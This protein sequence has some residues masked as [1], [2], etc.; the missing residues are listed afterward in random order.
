MTALQRALDSLGFMRDFATVKERE[1]RHT[2]A[3]IVT[4]WANAIAP[5]L[6]GGG[7]A[8]AWECREKSRHGWHAWDPCSQDHFDAFQNDT[9]TGGVSCR[10][11]MEVR[12]LYAHQAPKLPDDVREAMDALIFGD[13]IT[14]ADRGVLV[15]YLQ[16]IDN[17]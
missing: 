2:L 16:E 6:E 4:R 10:E 5:A 13:P 17:G 9:L 7:E 12:A 15:A 14:N 8:V 11:F 3:A 1:G